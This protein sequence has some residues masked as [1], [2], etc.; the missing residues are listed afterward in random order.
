VT[1][2]GAGCGAAVQRIVAGAALSWDG[3]F[4]PEG[5]AAQEA[6][7]EDDGDWRATAAALLRW[8]VHLFNDFEL[9]FLANV[10]SFAELS[11]RQ[12]AWLRRLAERAGLAQKARRSAKAA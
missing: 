6:L 7:H 3:I 8:H 12:A 4:V 5:G 11:P 10:G 2:G 9:R 1:E